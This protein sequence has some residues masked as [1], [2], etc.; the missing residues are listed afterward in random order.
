MLLEYEIFHIFF[1]ILILL[2]F[3]TKCEAMKNIEIRFWNSL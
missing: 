3:K 1:Q 2:W